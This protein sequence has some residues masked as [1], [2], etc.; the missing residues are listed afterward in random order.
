MQ[1]RGWTQ[2][3]TL[4]PIQGPASVLNG[5]AMAPCAP[6][7]CVWGKRVQA[8]T[9]GVTTSRPTSWSLSLWGYYMSRSPVS[10]PDCAFEKTPR[11][12]EVHWCSITALNM[13]RGLFSIWYEAFSSP[14]C[15]PRQMGEQWFIDAVEQWLGEWMNISWAPVTV[16]KSWGATDKWVAP[17]TLDN[18][19]LSSSQVEPPFLA[20]PIHPECWGISVVDFSIQSMQ[21]KATASVFSYCQLDEALT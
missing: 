9:G 3:V 20:S 15:T 1:G 2:G 17:S 4:N 21:R 16:N 19:F 8:E 12:E 13:K 14:N 5:E 18:G 10:Q 6:L 11:N 7:Y